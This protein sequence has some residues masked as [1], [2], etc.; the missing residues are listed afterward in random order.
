V[1][2]GRGASFVGRAAELCELRELLETRSLVTIVGEGGVGKTR[3]ARAVADS[4]AASDCQVWWTDLGAA[5]GP[6]GVR[7]SFEDSLRPVGREASFEELIGERLPAGRCVMVIDNCEHVLD[8]IVARIQLLGSIRPEARLL[9]TSRVRLGVSGEVA[10]RLMPLDVPTRDAPSAQVGD[11]ASVTLLVDR[12]RDVISGFSLDASNAADLAS[13][14][15]RTEGVP[16]AIELV[17]AAAGALPLSE[18]ARDLRESLGMGAV[19]ARRE[20]RRHRSLDASVRWSVDRLDPSTGVAF[21]RLGAFVESF[22]YDAA[23]GVISDVGDR[24]DRG[25]AR[26]FVELVEASLVRRLTDD[27]FSLPMA[28]RT[29][30]AEELDATAE[31]PEVRD[32]HAETITDVVMEVMTDSGAEADGDEVWL[33]LLDHELP[34]IRAAIGWQLVRGRPAQAAD[35]VEAAYDHAHIRGRYSEVLGQCR[36]ILAHPDLQRAAGARLA[37]TAS[38]V[39]VMAGRLA[40][41][42]G[43][44]VR[45]V[46]D[47]DD[48]VARANAHLQRAW[49]GYF[50]GLIGGATLWSDVD[51]ALRIAEEQH[52]DEL[53][54]VARLRKGSLVVQARSIP[55]GR[56]ILA[57]VAG[58]GGLHSHDLLAACLFQTYG[59]AVFDL[60]LDSSYSQVLDVIDDCRSVGHIAFESMALATAGT[61]A[62]LW[63]DEERTDHFLEEAERLVSDHDLPT[64]GNVVQRWRAFAAYRF[65][66]P[67]AEDHA[68]RAVT[69]AE[70]TDNVWDAAAAHWL[71]GLVTLH[72]SDEGA[73]EHLHTALDRSS[74]P[75]FPFSRIR[76]ELALSLIDLRNDDFATGL[77]RVHEALRRANDHCDL[78]GVAASFDHLA[79]FE[80]ERAAFDRAGRFAGAADAIHRR[81]RVER[82]PC[83]RGIRTEVERRLV[84]LAG[85]E[86]AAQL[87]ATGRA[88]D[89][90]AAVRLARRSRG[91]RSRPLTGWSSLT[92][93][94]SEVADL[95][96]RG[97][98]NPAIAD[99]LVMSVNTVKTHLSHV[100]AK[101]GVPGR[102]RLAAEW[103]RRST[104]R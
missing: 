98:S 95:A 103:D 34:E 78:L 87:V 24:H 86:E 76:A 2:H 102:S 8:D 96:A 41:S 13:I 68:G 104:G 6:S 38:I 21:R 65:D 46:K 9:A 71:L 10:Y 43:F 19:D 92:P 57:S 82:L 77:D 99:R 40:D 53:R 83:E 94:E 80:C 45:A 1:V 58:E 74:E 88:Q 16:L 7:S 75:G 54:A 60:E 72:N 33:R 47:A 61:I 51:E 49:S 50:S 30:A 23:V 100:Y 27:R 31:A 48:P 55:E 91:R 70:A 52:D 15:R 39:S 26:A 36:T 84:D 44:A 89:T 29:L 59:T 5:T 22:R 85:A 97:L 4:F 79:R 64:F 32:R 73:V 17:A 37:A 28:V 42:Y 12:L 81:S 66:R 67:D 62:A 11:I 69:L 93:T 18:I 56:T 25:A 90:D 35:L 63:G 101:T 14:A 3:L 20:P